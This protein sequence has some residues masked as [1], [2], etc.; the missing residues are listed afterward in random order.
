MYV[1]LVWSLRVSSVEARETC[2]SDTVP[3]VSTESMPAGDGGSWLV[4]AVCKRA[5]ARCRMPLLE[6]VT[7]FTVAESSTA[8]VP[9]EAELGLGHGVTC[10]EN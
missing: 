6:D 10:V 9:L 5:K 7:S 8:S 3:V 1:S 4:T 2:T